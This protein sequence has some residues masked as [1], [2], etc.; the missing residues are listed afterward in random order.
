MEETRPPRILRLYTSTYGNHSFDHGAELCKATVLLALQMR[1]IVLLKMMYPALFN[2]DFQILTRL[3]TSDVM[4]MSASGVYGI[5]SFPVRR[6]PIKV[7]Y[8]ITGFCSFNTAVTSDN[9]V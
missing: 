1:K 6:L 9:M 8:I 3:Y 5:I 4:A 2:F 7:P